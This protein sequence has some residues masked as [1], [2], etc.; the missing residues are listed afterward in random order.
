MQVDKDGWE[1]NKKGYL[2]D[3]N[4]NV[5]EERSKKVMFKLDQLDESGEIPSPH[6]EEKYNFNP[7]DVTGAF[8]RDAQ[9]KP[10]LRQQPDGK[11]LD[12]YGW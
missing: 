6:W 9:G 5:I 11:L 7:H 1:V 2:I 3:K 4:G 12:N 10:I 8:D